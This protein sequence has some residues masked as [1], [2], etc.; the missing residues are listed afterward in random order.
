MD[1]QLHFNISFIV[2]LEQ[3]PFLWCMLR[4]VPGPSSC[5][6]RGAEVAD[7][8]FSFLHFL[9]FKSQHGTDLC[10]GEGKPI[11]SGQYEVA[12]PG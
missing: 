7:K 4:K 9:L 6:G 12:S 8:V 10:Q 3:F 5:P 1:L 2:F 11:I